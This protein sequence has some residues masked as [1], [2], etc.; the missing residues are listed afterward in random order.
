MDMKRN[1]Y[2]AH[3]EKFGK[4]ALIRGMEQYEE[5]YRRSLDA[6]D[7]FWS[8]QAREYLTW[9]REWDFVLRQNVD[10][11]KIEWFGGGLLNAS[12]NCL[13]RH[14]D[15]LAEKVAYFWEGDDPGDTRTL[16]YGEL[17][18]AVNRFA[19]L[20]KSLGI[21]KGDRI[22]LFMPMVVEL[23]VAMLA[24]ARIGAIHCV[25]FSGY[26][27]EYLANRAA[28]CKARV[29]VTA[30]GGSRGGK[31]VPLK[32][33]VDQAIEINPQVENVLVFSRG[34]VDSRL[35]P[36]RD[37]SVDEALKDQSPSVIVEPEPMDAEDPLFITFASGA[38]G[39][40][41]ALVHTHGG[42]LLWVAMTSRLVFDLR[43]DETFWCTSNI[44]WAN[45]QG[46]SVY[47]PLL[48]G[49]SAVLFEGIPGHPDYGRYWKIVDK[50]RVN[51]FYTVP[52]VIRTLVREGKDD[53]D[54][55]DLSSLR[56][57]G[58]AGEHMT[59][60]TW[61]WLYQ[62]VGREK[63]P[64]MD[65][66]WQTESGG[67]MMTP[68]P[69]VG[70]IKPGSVSLPFF[71]VD[72]L[73][74][75]LDTGE[76][77][78]FP[79]QEGAFFIRRPWPGMARTI[80]GD[81]EAFKEAYFAPFG[82]MF[83]TGDGAR[84]DPDGFYVMTGRIDDVIN[85]SGHRIGSWEIETCL[86]AHDAV[87]EAAAVGFPHP[88]KGEGIYVFITLSRGNI[89]TE[90]LKQ[91][92]AEVLRLRIG[93]IATPDAIQWAD[94][95][96]RTRSGKILRRLLQKIAKGRIDDLGDLSTVANPEVVEALIR[97]RLGIP[98]RH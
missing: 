2:D 74:L 67:P 81:H 19:A 24:C 36:G 3:L 10:E 78:Q 71:G 5:L 32:P 57:L 28:D 69:G 44:G 49:V 68:L 82:G 38:I 54:K 95:L 98:E 72:P 56:I 47:G 26:S 65:T 34:G 33:I 55:Y 43:P 89:A 40:P 53:P 18:L 90:A 96:P 15:R 93:P 39:N 27:A 87:A 77:T 7:A 13:D 9:F 86:V 63:C 31:F 73:I 16:T 61:E 85:V 37:M 12:Y 66:W 4:T 76:E 46:F 79:N 60:Q 25:V 58:S 14:L 94:A 17:H 50:Y 11:A 45:G 21:K 97:D 1:W 51:K 35:H 92:L 41:R 30:T 83:I 62:S 91:E 8:E 75:D 29:I 70:P 48:N 42:Y 59:A 64:I 88:L 80:Y 52:T 20:L 23:P 84:K 22:V 6:A